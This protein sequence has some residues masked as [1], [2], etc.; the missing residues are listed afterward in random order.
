MILARLH[1]LYCFDCKTLQILAASS[2][3][4]LTWAEQLPSHWVWG[5]VCSQRSQF[6]FLKKSM[7]IYSFG[8]NLVII[9]LREC[10]TWV[11]WLGLHFQHLHM[12][13]SQR[14]LVPEMKPLL[15]PQLLSPPLLLPEMIK[16]RSLASLCQHESFH[17]TEAQLSSWCWKSQYALFLSLFFSFPFLPLHHSLPIFSLVIFGLVQRLSTQRSRLFFLVLTPLQQCTVIN[18]PS[19][20]RSD[21]AMK[22]ELYFFPA[23]F[24]VD[25]K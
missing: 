14:R 20:I 15:P 23:S 22:E 1:L 16:E 2:S 19:K 17:S 5:Q 4:D 6:S 3:F 9:R 7:R 24:W 11:S 18:L 21:K 8:P 13:R 10:Q 25:L 12:E